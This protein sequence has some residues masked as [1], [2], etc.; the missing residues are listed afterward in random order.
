MFLKLNCDF[1]NKSFQLVGANIQTYNR[2]L[3]VNSSKDIYCF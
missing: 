2:F 1:L 3:Y